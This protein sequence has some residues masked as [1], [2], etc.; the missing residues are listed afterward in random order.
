MLT[1]RTLILSFVFILTLVT[2]FAP[3]AASDGQA[4]Q[5]H[6]RMLKKRATSPAT[7]PPETP[8]KDTE[9]P[10]DGP[11]IGV[12]EDPHAASNTTT[13]TGTGT[14]TG[15]STTSSSSTTTTSST[16]TSVRYSILLPGG[17][18][19]HLNF[20]LSFF[21]NRLLRL[22]P[23]LLLQQAQTQHPQPQLLPARLHLHRQQPLPPQIIPQLELSPLLLMQ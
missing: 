20:F 22:R 3:S 8:Q 12:A 2:L 14:G 6:R 23:V 9:S 1:K 13:T 11:A 19:V 16:T 5:P 17:R 15:T 18:T 21:E 7:S 4:L 10:A